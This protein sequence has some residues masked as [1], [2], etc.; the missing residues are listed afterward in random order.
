MSLVDRVAR[1]FCE[2]IDE[3]RP[4]R[5]LSDAELTGAWEDCRGVSRELQ[6][7]AEARGETERWRAALWLRR[8]GLAPHGDKLAS[9]FLAEHLNRGMCAEPRQ[10]GMSPTG[11]PECCSDATQCSAKS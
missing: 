11:W 3:P 1:P 7:R 10:G 6:D 4:L 9:I 8:W 2:Q 5:L